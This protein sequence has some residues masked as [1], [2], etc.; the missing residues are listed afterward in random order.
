MSICIKSLVRLSFKVAGGFH[1]DFL[2][3]NF[4]VA[5]DKGSDSYQNLF[6]K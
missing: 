3:M 4:L 2:E 1:Q 5:S 6:T